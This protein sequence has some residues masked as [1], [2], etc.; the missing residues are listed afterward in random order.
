MNISC[1]KRLDISKNWQIFYLYTLLEDLRDFLQISLLISSEFKRCKQ[2]L[3]P[4]NHQKIYGFHM[5]SGEE[6]GG[7]SWLLLLNL[8]FQKKQK[9]MNSLNN[10][11]E[12][13]RRFLN[14]RGDWFALCSK[15]VTTDPAVNF[16]IAGKKL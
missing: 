11:I 5:I 13:W 16:T 14:I 15:H 7:R 10:K 6:G 9:L 4:W 8:Y 2:L 12:M 1:K 3:S